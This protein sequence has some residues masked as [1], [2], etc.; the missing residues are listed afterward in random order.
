MVIAFVFVLVDFPF[1]HGIQFI[2]DG[3]AGFF[4]KSAF[5]DYLFAASD[6]SPVIARTENFDLYIQICIPFFFW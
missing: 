6:I 4:T 2:C 3:A 5:S 1:L